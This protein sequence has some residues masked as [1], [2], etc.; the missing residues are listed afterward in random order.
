MS[1]PRSTPTDRT[2]PLRWA[3]T[4]APAGRAVEMGVHAGDTLRIIAEHRDDVWGFDSFQGLPERWREGF[5]RGKFACPQPDVPGATIV[6]GLFADTLPRWVAE[7]P[8]PVALLHLDADLYSSTV[9][10]MEHLGPLLR[11]GSVVVL[12]E[13]WGFDG[14]HEHEARAWHEADLPHVLH[15][16]DG[17]EQAVAVIL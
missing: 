14:W 5:E 3:L 17:Y 7:H 1:W 4:I 10:A 16:A 11:S 2:D 8:E 12:D 9:T 13:Y 15:V 6:P